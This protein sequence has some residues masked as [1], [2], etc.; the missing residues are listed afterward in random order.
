MGIV[1][2]AQQVPLKRLV[3]LK[4]ILAE[5]ETEQVQA[6]LRVEAESVARLRHPNIVQ[7]HEIGEHDGRM[8][9]ALEYVEGGSLA[10]KLNGNPLPPG[11]AA[12]LL[13]TLARAIHHAHQHGIVHR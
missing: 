1:Y 5:T 2:L 10:Q 13:E 7:I 11:Q 12:Q 3:A 8:Y 9:L 6:R 4:M